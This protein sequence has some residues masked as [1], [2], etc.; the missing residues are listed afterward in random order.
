MH[1]R[2]FSGFAVPYAF[3]GTHLFLIMMRNHSFVQV[4]QSNIFVLDIAKN[5]IKIWSKG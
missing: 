4:A 5:S 2:T 1:A 3:Q